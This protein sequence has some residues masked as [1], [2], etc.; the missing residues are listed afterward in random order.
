MNSHELAQFLLSHPD[1]PVESGPGR[2][3]TADVYDVGGF[4]C[5]ELVFNEKSG[6]FR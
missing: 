6:I 1:I 5:V 4:T 3:T 2:L